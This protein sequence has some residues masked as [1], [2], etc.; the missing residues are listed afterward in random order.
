MH[1]S[2]VQNASVVPVNM[3][4]EMPTNNTAFFPY[5]CLNSSIVPP[6]PNKTYGY[7]HRQLVVRGKC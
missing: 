2:P 1:I 7:F 4:N 3:H 5:V 6:D